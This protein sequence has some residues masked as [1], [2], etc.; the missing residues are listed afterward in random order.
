MARC[1]TGDKPLP[2]PL[3]ILLLGTSFANLVQ[4]EL[5]QTSVGASTNPSANFNGDLVKP[6]LK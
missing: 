5:V 2:E 1:G 3:D 6:L 4:H